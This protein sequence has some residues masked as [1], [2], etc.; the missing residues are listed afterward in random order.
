MAN[1]YFLAA[2]LPTIAVG[3][4]PEITFELFKT[5]ALENLNKKDFEKMVLLLRPIDFENVKANLNKFPLDYRGNL[6]EIELDEALL[7]QSELP[8]YFFEFL[9]KYESPQVAIQNI[10]ELFSLFFTTEAPS[11]KGF[12]RKYLE[13]ER[14]YRIVLA[15]LRA[16]EI[17]RDVIKEMQFED[18]SDLLVA[19]VI[20]QRDMETYEPP[21]EFSQLKDL[22]TRTRSDP[23]Q[24][25]L[26][27]EQYR[28][29]KIGELVE[30]AHLFSIDWVLA[31]MLQLI[32][33]ERVWELDA[34][35]AETVFQKFTAV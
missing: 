8:D 32:I 12:V 22:F 1:Y 9:A 10:S 29:D 18:F 31:Y 11:Q 21:E 2:S 6:N 13:F 20:A 4:K 24:R 30:D 34:G 23:L 19:S 27:I 16:K 3:E 7:T 14:A 17:K 33:V 26:S 25:A 5:G 35:K 15:A 28:F